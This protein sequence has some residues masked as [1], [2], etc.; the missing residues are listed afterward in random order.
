MVQNVLT[1]AD[2]DR[3]LDNYTGRVVS[4][5]PQVKTTSN[6]TGQETLTDGTAVNIKAHIFRTNQNWD[7]AKAGFLEKGNAVM[8][9]KYADSV[10]KDDVISMEGDKF[11]VRESFDVNGVYDST[12]SGTSFV[13]TASNLFLIE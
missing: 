4:H 3:V 9:S 8:L 7:F 5:I 6:I 1:V 11:R 12:G 10:G 2:F 13:Y